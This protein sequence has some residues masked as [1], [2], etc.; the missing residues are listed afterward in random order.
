MDA[1]HESGTGVQAAV[2]NMGTDDQ[3]TDLEIGTGCPQE[4][5]GTDACHVDDEKEAGSSVSILYSFDLWRDVTIQF[6][7]NVF[8]SYNRH[9]WI[10]NMSLA[11]VFK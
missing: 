8:F 6:Y 5:I 7:K 4:E 1:E 3:R 2:Q 11:L 9:M 10:L